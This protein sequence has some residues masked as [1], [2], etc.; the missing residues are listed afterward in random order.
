MKQLLCQ[1]K[2]EWLKEASAL[3]DSGIIENAKRGENSCMLQRCL[4]QV[5][6]SNAFMKGEKN[7]AC[8]NAGI[9]TLKR[10]LFNI[11]GGDSPNDK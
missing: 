7:C 9:T 3:N 4:R 2:I 10:A 6:E 1:T 8:F 5:Y 11:G